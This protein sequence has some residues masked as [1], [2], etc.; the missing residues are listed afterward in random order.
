LHLSLP[1]L[2]ARFILSIFPLYLQKRVRKREI[3]ARKHAKN[4]RVLHCECILMKCFFCFRSVD[5]T[6]LKKRL[7]V[8][9]CS[10]ISCWLHVDFMFI[11]HFL[12]RFIFIRDFVYW[13][14]SKKKII[15]WLYKLAIQLKKKLVCFNLTQDDRILVFLVVVGKV[16]CEESF[17]NWIDGIVGKFETKK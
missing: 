5:F 6:C 1:K 10:M 14:S 12:C 13:K 15:W 4:K 17:C 2:S 16:Y 3:Q 7:S 11:F 8:V 9:W